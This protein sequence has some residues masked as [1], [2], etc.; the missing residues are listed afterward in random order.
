MKVYVDTSALLALVHRDDAHHQAVRAATAELAEAG[1][2]LVTTSYV[3]VESGALVQR[4]LGLTAF[5]LLGDAVA[6]AMDVIWV[7]AELHDPAWEGVAAGSKRGPS[8][9]DRVGLAVM[10]RLAIG[11]ALAVDRH[12]RAAGFDTLPSLSARG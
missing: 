5:R 8:L 11:T 4:R 9:V 10:Q 7:D 6:R 2:H 1:A 12:F 3:L